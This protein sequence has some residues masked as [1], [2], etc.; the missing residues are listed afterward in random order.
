MTWE[1]LIILGIIV[2]L[3]IFALKIFKFVMKTTFFVAA[4]LVLL[5]LAGVI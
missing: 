3:V 5:K 2:L 4:L 1:L